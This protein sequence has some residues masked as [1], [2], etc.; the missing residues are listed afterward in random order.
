MS[1]IRSL[2]TGLDR[3]GFLVSAGCAVH[4]AAMPFAAGLLSMYG[5]GF[6]ASDTIEALL[7]VIAAVVAVASM[8]GGCR[9]HRQLR[10]ILLMPLGFALVLTGRALAR[11]GGWIET[12]AVV[13]GGALI[14]SAHLA[15]WR[16][17]CAHHPSD[18]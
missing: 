5:A 3:V 12:L 9:H 11:E 18:R 8:S 1:I 6:V 14:A 4:C 7:L 16:L 17:C 10:P 15:N 13:A 2:P